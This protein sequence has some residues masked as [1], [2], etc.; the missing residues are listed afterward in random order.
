MITY[1][2]FIEPKMLKES[3]VSIPSPVVTENAHG[4]TIALFADTHFGEY[5]ALTDFEKVITMI[6]DRNPDIVIFA[7]DLIDSFYEYQ[8]NVADISSALDKINSKYGKFAVFGNHDYGGGAERKYKEIMETGGFM[9][10]KN[11][12]YALD[13]LG[14]SIIGIDD[15]LIGY[16]NTEIASWA[17][18]DYFNIAISHAPDVIDEVLNNNI[19]LM[20]SGHT[21]G[22]QVNLPIL[23]EYILPPGGRNY[24]KGIFDFENHR[25]TQLYVNS[26]IGTTKKPIRF[27]SPP[28]IT[29]LTIEKSQ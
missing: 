28:E 6:N 23:D 11:E 4:L 7:G 21:H 3:E 5:Y 25:N 17:R 9:V 22:R 18:E 19:D 24:V 15:M 29:F 10:L 27:L 14:V 16:G 26:G 8:G 1:A 12:Y 2:R 13:A 20:L